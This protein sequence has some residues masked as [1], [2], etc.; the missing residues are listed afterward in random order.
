MD[1][2]KENTK[3]YAK[4][5]KFVDDHPHIGFILVVIAT[6]VLMII[7]NLVSISLTAPL[8]PTYPKEVYDVVNQ[9]LTVGDYTPSEIGSV[10]RIVKGFTDYFAFFSPKATENVA[11]QMAP[12]LVLM[13]VLLPIGLGFIALMI[14]AYIIWFVINYWSVLSK[15]YGKAITTIGTYVYDMGR[16]HILRPITAS[17]RPI[18]LDIPVVG[19]FN[20]E[21]NPFKGV[22]TP[23]RAPNIFVRSTEWLY[24]NI[25]QPLSKKKNEL[26]ASING[27]VNKLVDAID[28]TKWDILK[29]VFG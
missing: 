24:V 15:A 16:Y 11:A 8:P 28:P 7:M 3:W 19:A 27:K 29:P 23:I 1:D 10:S 5:V 14:L 21:L 4:Y 2:K 26:E 13:P 22:K 17:F 20:P 25:M 6:L 9:N 12:L 18:N